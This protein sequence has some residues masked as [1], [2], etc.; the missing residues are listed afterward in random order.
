MT[1]KKVK[2]Y[3]ESV[4]WMCGI[5]DKTGVYQIK[6]YESDFKIETINV[7]ERNGALIADC[8]SIGI[9]GAA[10]LCNGLTD[11]SFIR[12]CEISK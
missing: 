10:E 6:S 4:K 2:P 8:P 5:I 7:L 12:I 11:F 3:I 9:V 1:K